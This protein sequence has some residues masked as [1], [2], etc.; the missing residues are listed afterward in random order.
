MRRKPIFGAIVVW[1]LA[2]TL[3]LGASPSQ[4]QPADSAQ[5]AA[6]IHTLLNR[7]YER[8]EAGEL[9]RARE[10]FLKVLEADPQNQRA[11]LELGYLAGRQSLWAEAVR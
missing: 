10:E 11:T 8:L 2:V 4:T 9:E 3:P 1:L 5:S 6:T 7:A